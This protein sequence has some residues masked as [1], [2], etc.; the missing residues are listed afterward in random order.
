MIMQMPRVLEGRR[1]LITG[2]LDKDSI[3]SSITEAAIKAG[4]EF[5]LLTYPTD[6]IKKR[7]EL[8][9][10]ALGALGGKIRIAQMDVLD[11][12]QVRD[13]FASIPHVLGGLDFVVHCIAYA[14]RGALRGV[15][16]ET[17]LDDFNVAMGTSAHS[18]ARLLK[19]GAPL[20]DERGG[21]VVALTYS[22][23]SRGA[24]PNYQIM[25]AAKAAL[26]TLI[27]YLAAEFGPR[28]IRV[29]GIA[30]GPMATMAAKG[31]RGFDKFLSV[32]RQVVPLR[33]MSDEQIREALGS[34]A[35][36]LLSDMSKYTTGAILPV[37][38]GFDA[39]G[40]QFTEKML[41]AMVDAGILS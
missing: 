20:M 1:G 11:E 21:S 14:P 32:A 31:I 16:S 40:V 35:V 6:A 34:A 10:P 18:L 38:G 23:G 39:L 15:V 8:T 25:G 22:P 13:V 27:R 4:A 28:N 19:Y 17:T 24:V 37:D 12:G 3:A 2:V 7:L 33:H 26:E 36:Y 29:N 9:L 30:S 41:V 5:V